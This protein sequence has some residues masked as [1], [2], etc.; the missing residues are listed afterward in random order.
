MHVSIQEAL[1]LLAL[2]G[3]VAAV[4]A[5]LYVASGLPSRA[6]AVRN[7]ASFADPSFAAGVVRG[8][9]IA[10]ITVGIYGIVGTG[11]CP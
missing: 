3:I 9:F 7:E 10:L 2:V 1:Q 5:V 4:L 6:S 11:G 8:V